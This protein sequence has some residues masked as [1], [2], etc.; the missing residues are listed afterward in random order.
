MVDPKDVFI[1]N[2]KVLDGGMISTIWTLVIEDIDDS[3]DELRILGD[4]GK[5][6]SL[7]WFR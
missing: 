5:F 1:L 6:F 3:I 4:D 7:N 2:G